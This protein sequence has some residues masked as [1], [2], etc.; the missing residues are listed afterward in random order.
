MAA[1]AAVGFAAKRPAERKYRST[2]SISDIFV[3]K[4]IFSFSFY[5][6]V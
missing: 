6:I 5:F 2:A 4:L 3:L 1:T